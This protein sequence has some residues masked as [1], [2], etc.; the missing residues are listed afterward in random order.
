LNPP[1]SPPG[2]TS[3]EA[4]RRLGEVGPN[5]LTEKKRSP[6]LQLFSYFWGPIPWMIEVAMVLSALIGRWEDFFIIGALLALNAG[7]GFLQERKADRAVAALKKKLALNAR[8][9][10]DGRWQEVAARTLVPGDLVRVRP[11]EIVPAD[12][13]GERTHRIGAPR[14]LRIVRCPSRRGDG[15]P[16]VVE[17]ERDGGADAARTRHAGDQCDPPGEWCCRWCHVSILAP[18]RRPARPGRTAMS[19]I[20][21]SERCDTARPS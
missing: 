16:E 17:P 21:R 8:V 10:R 18:T 13:E 9:L 20:S 11:G 12:G 7:V 3:L 19:V 14:H 15:R 5:E 6:V 4:E 1:N 2:L